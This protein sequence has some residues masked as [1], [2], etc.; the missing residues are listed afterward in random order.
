[1]INL[2]NFL[3]IRSISRYNVSNLKLNIVHGFPWR[4]VWPFSSAYTMFIESNKSIIFHIAPLIILVD[5][6]TMFIFVNTRVFPIAVKAIA[7]SIAKIFPANWRSIFYRYSSV[8][9]ANRAFH[10]AMKPFTS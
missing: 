3:L 6:P 5:D 10:V 9:F 2:D 7:A 4:R 1:M 8:P